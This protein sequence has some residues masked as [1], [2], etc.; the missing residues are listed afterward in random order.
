MYKKKWITGFGILILVFLGGCLK[1]GGQGGGGSGD[2]VYEVIMTH[3]LPESFFKHDYME[4]FKEE[5]EEKSD[6]RLDIKIHPAAQLYDDGEAMQN[7]GTG[8]VHI[9]WPVS[10]HL[11]DIADEYGL[12]NLPFSITDE[13]VLENENYR[14]DLT[15]LLDSFVEDK[16]V[17]VFGL[18]RTSEGIILSN[19]EM[20]EME[21][22]S[23]MKIRSV[24]GHVAEDLLGAFDASATSLPSTEITTSLSQGVID[25]VNTSPDGWNDIVGS[26][27][28]YGLVVP[29]MQVLTYSMI[30]DRDWFDELPD[31]LQ[32]I[33]EETHEE[34]ITEQWEESIDIDEEEIE[35]AEEDYGTVYRVP[36]KE[37]DGWKK[38]TEEVYDLFEKDNPGV[39]EEFEEIKP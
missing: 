11:E 37:V 8:S 3:E 33:I 25:G 27:A 34:M 24:G 22:L 10:V 28:E 15:N 30:A 36:E 26:T 31:D 38:Q 5:A 39:L 21:D 7:L 32:E 9:V 18:M 23:G 19:E 1:D 29:Q 16:G 6:G 12:V 17:K 14:Q 4:Q 13:D 35:E 20:K 2:E